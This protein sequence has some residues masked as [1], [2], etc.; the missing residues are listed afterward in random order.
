[1]KNAV[2]PQLEKRGTL[3]KVAFTA[4]NTD[5]QGELARKLMRGGSIPQLIVFR[6][7]AK[8]WRREQFTGAR[9]VKETERFISRG[10]E[11]PGTPLTARQ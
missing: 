4:V 1:M 10:S 8:G 11:P 5:Q 6:R 2:I 7:T 3:R 9:S